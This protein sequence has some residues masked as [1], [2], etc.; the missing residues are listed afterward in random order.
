M[1]IRKTPAVTRPTDVHVFRVQ[2]L[3][4][5]DLVLLLVDLVQKALDRLVL[6]LAQ[7]LQILAEVELDEL[8]QLP[9]QVLVLLDLFQVVSELGLDGLQ[10]LFEPGSV[11]GWVVR[12]VLGDPPG[13]L[14]SLS[15]QVLLAS[16]AFLLARAQSSDQFSVD[17]TRV[18]AGLFAPELDHLQFVKITEGAFK[19][20]VD[21]L[22]KLVRLFAEFDF[23]VLHNHF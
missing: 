14:H 23:A 9:D 3:D 21:E 4:Q 6:A 17:Q 10:V 20:D 18:F 12:A 22:Q 7:L 11:V 5:L 16:G 19:N 13:A 1:L 15:E 8:V 2:R